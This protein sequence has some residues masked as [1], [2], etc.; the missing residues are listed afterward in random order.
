MSICMNRKLWLSQKL[1]IPTNWTTTNQITHKYEHRYT[2]THW[3]MYCDTKGHRFHANTRENVYDYYHKCDIWF[4]FICLLSFGCVLVFLNSNR[5]AFW[6]LLKKISFLLHQHCVRSA[7]G[8]PLSMSER[9]FF[10]GKLLL[11]SF[12]FALTISLSL[13]NFTLNFASHFLKIRLSEKR[14]E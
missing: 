10:V 12:F 2:H 3:Y 14:A 13:L 11:L 1:R 7:S 4:R 9:N 8:L 5:K 6:H